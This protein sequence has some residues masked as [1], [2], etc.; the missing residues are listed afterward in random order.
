[1][2]IATGHSYLTYDEWLEKY[3]IKSELDGSPAMFDTHSDWDYISKLDP[4]L[5][6][7][8]RDNGEEGYINNGIG[9][10]DRMEYYVANKPW[11]DGEYVE[12]RW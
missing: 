9:W 10:V 7:T 2:T 3:D 8:Y 1:M 5:V 6:W 12:V 4:K 11:H